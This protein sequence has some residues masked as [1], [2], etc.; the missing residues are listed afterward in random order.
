[1]VWP[2]YGRVRIVPGI[3]SPV[4]WAKSTVAVRVVEAG[5]GAGLSGGRRTRRSASL[6]ISS[7]RRRARS[8]RPPSALACIRQAIR[9]QSQSLLPDRVVS[10]KTSTYRPRSSLTVNRLRGGDLARHVQSFGHV[11]SAFRVSRR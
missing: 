7:A 11:A 4:G 2:L 9:F 10:P 8:D 6:A 3:S 1:M 5:G